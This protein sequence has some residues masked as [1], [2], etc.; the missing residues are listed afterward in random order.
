MNPENCKSVIND[1]L[2][3]HWHVVLCNNATL[4][5]KFGNNIFILDEKG[6]RVHILFNKR[7]FDGSKHYYNEMFN[8][9]VELLARLIPNFKEQIWRLRKQ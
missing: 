9:K 5:Q 7:K 1:F 4:T 3:N 8:D 6:F 2:D